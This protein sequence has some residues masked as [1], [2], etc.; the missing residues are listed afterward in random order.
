MDPEWNCNDKD[1]LNWFYDFL[2]WILHFIQNL[3]FSDDVCKSKYEFV[4]N[5][6]FV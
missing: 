6:T 2:L 5:I 3:K 1:H 4:W